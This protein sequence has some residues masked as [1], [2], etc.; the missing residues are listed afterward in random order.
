VFLPSKNRVRKKGMNLNQLQCMLCRAN[1]SDCICH[2]PQGN[3]LKDS[4]IC[5]ERLGVHKAESSF[6]NSSSYLWNFFAGKNSVECLVDQNTLVFRENLACTF[7]S[8][9]SQDLRRIWN[10]SFYRFYTRNIYCSRNKK[11]HCSSRH[12]YFLPSLSCLDTK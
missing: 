3:T 10:S 1:R 12:N 7:D 11:L 2:L 8:R 4:N 9:Y 5:I 6:Q